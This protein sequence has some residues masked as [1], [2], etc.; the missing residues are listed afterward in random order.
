MNKKYITI[1]IIGVLVLAVL[2]GG[3]WKWNDLIKK[4]KI[5]KN[6]EIEN[7]SQE[8]LYKIGGG[9]AYYGKKVY[10]EG[11]LLKNIDNFNFEYLGNEFGKNENVVL[12]KGIVIENAE[13]KT[14]KRAKE[15][16][17]VYTDNNRGYYK[18]EI[19]TLE[20][21][22]KL[23]NFLSSGIGG[24]DLGNNYRLY[25]GKIY[26]WNTY[27]FQ[28]MPIMTYIDADPETFKISNENNDLAKDKNNYY[29][30]DTKINEE[31]Y[32][33]KLIDTEKINKIGKLKI[34]DK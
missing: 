30:R 17:N 33:R 18:G 3:F 20:E 13:A 15:W 4:E 34:V 11:K 6:Y 2:A 7:P 14:F 12:Y 28:A 21:A 29:F 16:L 22:E 25:D 32:N 1:S 24:E 26:Y 27:G 10:Y 23:I 5:N 9:Y 8:Q 19:I 31:E